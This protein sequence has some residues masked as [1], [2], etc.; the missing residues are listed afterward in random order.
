MKTAYSN[1]T[2]RILSSTDIDQIKDNYPIDQ[3]LNIALKYILD[4]S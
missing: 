4:L 2:K 1:T 3:R